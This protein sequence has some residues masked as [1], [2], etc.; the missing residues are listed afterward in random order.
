MPSVLVG[1]STGWAMTPHPTLLRKPGKHGRFTLE[2]I[3]PDPPARYKVV[4]MP[5]GFFTVRDAQGARIH[6]GRGPVEVV[7]SPAPF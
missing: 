2:R 7:R 5:K 6:F 3:L 4:E 1:Y